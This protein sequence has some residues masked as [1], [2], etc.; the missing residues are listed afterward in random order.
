MLVSP[1][2]L[3]FFRCESDW[4]F[5]FR[6]FNMGKRKEERYTV[7]KE[8]NRERDSFVLQRLVLALPINSV[9]LQYHG[10]PSP[11]APPPACVHGPALLEPIKQ[12][13]RI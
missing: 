13:R 1:H 2:V 4:R 11:P 3:F 8:T 9:C 5:S 6:A 10:V 7:R 12:R